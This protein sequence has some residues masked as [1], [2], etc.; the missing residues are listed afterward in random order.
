M[1][2]LIKFN[3]LF[4][5]NLLF[6]FNTPN[7]TQGYGIVMLFTNTNGASP[8][9]TFQLSNFCTSL[10]MTQYLKFHFLVHSLHFGKFGKFQQQ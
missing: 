7:L 8:P 5:I 1:K 10:Q 3:A 4:E 9:S 6:I 2:I